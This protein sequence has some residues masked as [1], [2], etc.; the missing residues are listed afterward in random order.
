MS[1]VLG[2]G[3]SHD[4]SAPMHFGRTTRPQLVRRDRNPLRWRVTDRCRQLSGIPL[5]LNTSFN[6]H[7]EPIVCQPKEAAQALFDNRIDCLAIGSF[8][9]DYQPGKA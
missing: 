6:V 5:V 2:I 7:E 8:W 9:A 3:S 4:V 1:V